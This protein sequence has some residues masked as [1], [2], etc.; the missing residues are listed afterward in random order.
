MYVYFKIHNTLFIFVRILWSTVLVRWIAMIATF[1]G[2]LNLYLVISLALY[3]FWLVLFT[4]SWIFVDIVDIVTIFAISYH[5]VIFRTLVNNF[6]YRLSVWQVFWDFWWN[7]FPRVYYC[8]RINTLKISNLNCKRAKIK[9]KRFN[10][11]S[12][13]YVRN[14]KV[15]FYDQLH[16]T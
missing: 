8:R 11:S 4:L 2:L 14:E 10:F 9:E 15:G 3:V 12:P 5:K 6:K 13:C 16:R 7:M 1:R